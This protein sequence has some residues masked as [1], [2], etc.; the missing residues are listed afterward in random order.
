VRFFGRT[1]SLSGLFGKPL[2]L[3]ARGEKL[4]AKVLK[5]AGCRILA[6]SYRCPSGEADLIALAG[7]TLVFAEVKT[8]SDDSFVSPESAVDGRKR[9]KYRRVAQYYVV[10]TGRDDLSI[11]FDIIAITIRPGGK[12]EIRHLVDAFS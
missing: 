7:D 9:Q 12:P 10:R 3:G 11:R 4:A 1:L 5:S 8:R 6:R 2:G